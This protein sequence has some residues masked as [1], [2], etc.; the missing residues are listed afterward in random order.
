MTTHNVQELTTERRIE[1]FLFELSK[2]T[3]KYGIEIRGCGRECPF[4][5]YLMGT[6]GDDFDG[7]AVDGLFY[8][9]ETQCYETESEDEEND[10]F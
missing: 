2:L 8:N 1:C 7:F 3:Q 5:P 10:T 6:D 4:C 9:H